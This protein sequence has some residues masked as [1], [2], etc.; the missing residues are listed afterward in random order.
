MGAIARAARDNP[1]ALDLFR[2]I[3]LASAAIPG[4]FPPTMI[5]VE[6]NGKPHEEMHVD[7]GTS[8]Q[9]F[10]YPVNLRD[11][12]QQ[13]HIRVFAERPRKAYLIRNA[14]LDPDWASVERSTLTIAG[15]AISSLIQTQG[16]G[17]LYRLSLLAQK[18]RLDFNL[19]YIGA[20]FTAE[21]QEDFDTKY[22]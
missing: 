11:A 12:A 7:G 21:H 10:L 2:R 15:R 6:V 9:L 16:V 1:Q 17:D 19:A 18:D 20:D 4:A 3:L 5:A 13:E 22:M 8:R 14:R